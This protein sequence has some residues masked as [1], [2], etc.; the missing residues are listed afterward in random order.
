LE[1]RRRGQ[2]IEGRMA[3]GPGRVEKEKEKDFLTVS[4]GRQPC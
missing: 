2:G 4:K 3:E 1:D